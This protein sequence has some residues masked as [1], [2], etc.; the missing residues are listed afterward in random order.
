M[1]QCTMKLIIVVNVDWFFL[2]HRLPIALEALRRGWQVLLVCSD[3]GRFE[4]IKSYGITPINLEVDRSGKNIFKERKVIHQLES[5]Y[6][7]HK[8]DV[9]HHVTMKIAIYGS[10]AAKKAG[11]ARVVNAISGLGFSF[12]AGRKSITQRVIL[13]L[14]KRAFKKQGQTFIFQNPDDEAMFQ[15]LGLGKGNS[16][17]I[18]KG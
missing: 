17:I 3:T 15:K 14:M 9:V 13:T 11:V 4:E 8:P 12:T 5:I 2:S 18:I 10:L 1:Q 6:K 7:E 16:S